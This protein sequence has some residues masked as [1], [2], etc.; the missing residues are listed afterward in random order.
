MRKSTVDVLIV[1][2][3]P[4][5]LAAG[6]QLKKSGIKNVR[7]IEREAH[8]GG[9]PRHSHHPG[10]GIRDLKRFISGPEYAKRYLQ[11][12]IAAGVEVST[13]TTATNWIDKNTLQLTAPSGIEHVRADAIILATGARERARAARSVAG[14]RGDGVYTTGSLQ[15]ATYLEKL[16]I[17]KKAVI[18][19]AEHVSL[20]AV[21]TLKDAGVKTVAMICPDKKHQT[22]FGAPTLLSLLFRFKYLANT[23][24]IELLGDSRVSGVRVEKDGKELLIDADTIIFTGDW[25][26]DHELVRRG[27]FAVDDKYKSPILTVNNQIPDTNIFVVGNLL[28]PIKAAD[29]C[30][31]AAKKVAKYIANQLLDKQKV[32]VA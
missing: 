23:Q 12:A 1:G 3:G 21:L 4:A 5:G 32:K 7:V 8:A 22:V 13:S 20:S 17:G 16:Y 25:I 14:K 28:L 10:Y 26:P 19:G 9:I 30:A 11:T 24:I 15:Q 27:G 2:A 29:Q 18:V 31:V 6:I